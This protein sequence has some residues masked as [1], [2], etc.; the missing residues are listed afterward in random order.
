MGGA[1]H[2]LVSYLWV[3]WRIEEAANV[4]NVVPAGIPSAIIIK[5]R[6]AKVS[7]QNHRITR[8]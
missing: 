2:D 4:H 7:A 5:A 6:A 8:A 3:L 1:T